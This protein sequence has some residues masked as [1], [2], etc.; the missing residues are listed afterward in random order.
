MFL[1]FQ[2]LELK[3]SSRLYNSLVK[4]GNKTNEFIVVGE[5][6]EN[7]KAQQMEDDGI[8]L[9]SGLSIDEF[10]LLIPKEDL[11]RKGVEV[12]IE[13]VELDIPK[14]YLS[15]DIIENIQNLNR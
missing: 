1:E 3:E 13:T 12:G 4:K 2:I 8:C 10:S 11:K 9:I 15:L 5:E 7:Y 6:S 14:K